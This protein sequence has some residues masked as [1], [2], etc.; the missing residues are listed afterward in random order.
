MFAGSAAASPRSR[1]WP[2][3]CARSQPKPRSPSH[4]PVH[5]RGPVNHPV[6]L[7]KTVFSCVGAVPSDLRLRSSSHGPAHG[8]IR[9]RRT[10]PLHPPPAVVVPRSRARSRPSPSPA[11]PSAY[12][13]TPPVRGRRPLRPTRRNCPRPAREPAPASSLRRLVSPNQQHNASTPVPSSR[14][15]NPR[16]LPN[17]GDQ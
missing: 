12:P 9:L 16:S 4:S 5:G 14:D 13:E 6:H 17:G 1:P 2:R 3:S 10:H 11:V 8:P 7:T 15:R